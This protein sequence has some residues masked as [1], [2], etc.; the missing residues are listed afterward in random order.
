L[1]IYP[2]QYATINSTKRAID[3][4]IRLSIFVVTG[5]VINSRVMGHFMRAFVIP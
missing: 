2:T 1:F 4:L 3:G 5:R